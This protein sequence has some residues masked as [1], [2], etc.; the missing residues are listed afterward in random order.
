MDNEQNKNFFDRFSE[1]ALAEAGSP[2]AFL[3]ALTLIIIWAGTG[4]Q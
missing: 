1:W 3:I 4:V 2:A